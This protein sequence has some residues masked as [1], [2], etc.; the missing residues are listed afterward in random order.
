MF[1]VPISQMPTISSLGGQQKV[2]ENSNPNAAIPFADV[3]KSVLEDVKSTQAVSEQ[4]AYNLSMGKAD[5]LHTIKI[6]SEQAATAI[7]LTVQLTSKAVNAY[8]EIMQI[9]V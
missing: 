1:I 8:K 5:D 6:H 3:F 4:D 9:Q 2:S 7:E